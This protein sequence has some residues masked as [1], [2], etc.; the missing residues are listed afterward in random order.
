MD[1]FSDLIVMDNSDSKCSD[2][3]DFFK[4]PEHVLKSDTI[5]VPNRK[6]ARVTEENKDFMPKKKLVFREIKVN[7]GRNM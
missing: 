6:R 1:S 3:Q 5:A 7:L 2:V 4:T